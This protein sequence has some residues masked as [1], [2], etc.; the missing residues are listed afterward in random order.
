[1]GDRTTAVVGRRMRLRPGALR[2]L[3]VL[4]VCPMLPA[5]AF[6]PIVGLPAQSGAYKQSSRRRSGG[7]AD[8]RDEALGFLFGGRRC[9]LWSI[10]DLGHRVL[11]CGR[12]R[13]G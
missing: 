9:G 7:L 3:R 12:E 13:D 1:M 2:A 8:I 5:D 10:T 11:N 4:E 6:G